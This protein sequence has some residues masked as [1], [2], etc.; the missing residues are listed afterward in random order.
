MFSASAGFGG[1]GAPAPAPGAFGSPAHI[2]LG[3]VPA[4]NADSHKLVTAIRD[5]T[6]GTPAHMVY[7]ID[8]VSVRFGGYFTADVRAELDKY[9][10]L[11]MLTLNDCGIVSLENFPNITSLIRIDMVFNS[12]PGEHLKYLSGLK[13]V[14]TLMIGANQIDKMEH[15]NSLKQMR[16]LLQLDLL[17]NDVV[18]VPGYRAQ[19]FT[20][21][22]SLS[23]LDTMDKI[24]KDSFNNKSMLE[25]ASRVPDGLFDKSIPPPPA[26]IHKP[27]H[28][29]EKKKLK[30]A[31]ART[32]SLDSMHSGGPPARLPGVRTARAKLGKAKAAIAAGKTRSSR[33]GLVFPVARIKRKLKKVMVGQ[34]T[35][36]GSA[37]YM[38]AVLE[39]LS[40]ELL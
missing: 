22:P 30:A 3:S 33:S 36:V 38:A 18:K 19:V 7:V 8:I 23:I 37:V 1:F 4:P 16:S 13:H 20:M 29:R 34:R 31:L 12:I 28:E 6:E 25:A 10:F 40:A 26:P 24:G 35:G 14:Q 32:G 17:N 2:A 15:L 27:I 9:R 5:Q 39:Y 11:Q 21:F